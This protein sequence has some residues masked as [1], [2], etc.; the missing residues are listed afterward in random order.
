MKTFVKKMDLVQCIQWTGNNLKEVEEFC[1]NLEGEC[2][3]LTQNNQLSIMHPLVKGYVNKVEVTNYIVKRGNQTFEIH[4]DDEFSRIYQEFKSTPVNKEK[5]KVRVES[6][7]LKIGLALPI[8]Y[9]T[10]DT[11][12]NNLI[13]SDSMGVVYTFNEDGSYKGYVVTK[14]GTAR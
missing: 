6:N 4:S 3:C 14:K 8:K 2:R 12:N 11:S 5:Q 1:T 9:T 7:I 13:I 10:D